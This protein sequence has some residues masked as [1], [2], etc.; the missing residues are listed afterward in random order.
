MYIKT[1]NLIVS[2]TIHIN[3]PSP[4][5]KVN[6]GSC[7]EKIEERILLA[8]CIVHISG[9]GEVWPPFHPANRVNS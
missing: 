4:H 5:S 2:M 7:H 9:Q 6:S 1:C 3:S 8:V